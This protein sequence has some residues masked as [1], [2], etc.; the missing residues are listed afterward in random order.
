[1]K[2]YRRSG[3]IFFY[4]HLQVASCAVKVSDPSS[5]YPESVEKIRVLWYNQIS[6]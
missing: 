2:R 6:V 1:M 5:G 4:A 3:G